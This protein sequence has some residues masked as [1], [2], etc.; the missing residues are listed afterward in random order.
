M[1]LEYFSATPY[2]CLYLVF[3]DLVRR[4]EGIGL[5]AASEDHV[6][7]PKLSPAWPW[8]QAM[9]KTHHVN[10]MSSP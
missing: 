9:S 3:S 8:A 7:Y 6:F 1:F 4:V 2:I 5:A 10:N